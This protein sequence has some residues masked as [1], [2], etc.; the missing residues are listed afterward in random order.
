M[1][2]FAAITVPPPAH[3][4]TATQFQAGPSLL[5]ITRILTYNEGDWE[6]FVNEWAAGYLGTTYKLVLRF[7]G[8]NDRGIDIAGFTDEERLLGTW[9][10]F[11]CKHYSH[12]LRPSN[13]W[14]EI[15]KIL[16]H[17]FN[18]HYRPPRRYFFVAPRNV[19]TTLAMYLA[20]SARLKAELKKVWNDSV[21]RAITDTQQVLLEG[22]FA[23]FV[24]DFDFR[25]FSE[26]PILELIAE[27][28]NTPYFL[29]RFGG[30]L[31]ARPMPGAPPDAVAPEENRYVQ[32]LLSAYAQHLGQSSLDLVELKHSGK[33]EQHFRRQRE[34][35]YHAEGLRVFVRD[36]VEPGTFESLQE[37]VFSGVVDTCEAT[38]ADG[39]TRV[40]AVMQMAQ[41]L[42]LLAHPLASVTFTRDRHGICH[43]LANEDRLKWAT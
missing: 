39:Y 27:H 26:K 30:G 40:V 22:G 38:Y 41:N 14:P 29:Q 25:I 32:E 2:D 4:G 21:S 36:K 42:P 5:P 11:Q 18:N 31:P 8:A 24:E 37:E 23:Q 34:A 19:G 6:L 17:S 12:P 1:D 13:V 43:Q 15:G 20:N 35:F 16:W 33:L 10:C 9:D 7:S 3:M 28:R